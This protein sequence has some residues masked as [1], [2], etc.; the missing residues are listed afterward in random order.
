MRLSKTWFAAMLLASC[1][2]PVLAQTNVGQ[3][4][5]SGAVKLSAAE[6]R[7]EV[8]GRFLE[9]PGRGA[10]M[11][12]ASSGQEVAYF[13]DGV[14]RGSGYT[15]ALGGISGGGRNFLIEGTWTIDE[16]DR[17]CQT[18]RAGNVVL[19]PRCQYWFK[20]SDKYYFADSDSDRSALVTVRTVKKI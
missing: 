6:F 1:V 3:L 7:Q 8:V 19:A 10:T 20:H 9:G 2:S 5:D 12:S 4:L 16:R 14:I 11:A 18:T 15:T 13:Q 17:V